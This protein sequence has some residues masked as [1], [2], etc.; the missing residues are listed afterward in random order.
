MAT[1]NRRVAALLGHLQSG[2]GKAAARRSETTFRAAA[3][4]WPSDL[5]G[6]ETIPAIAYLGTARRTVSEDPTIDLTI[7][8]LEAVGR[9][10]PVPSLIMKQGAAHPDPLVSWTA[11][12]LVELREPEK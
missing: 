8:V 7:C 6:E 10:P 1:S 12:R 2:E 9:S 3:D 11:K 4:L 5:P